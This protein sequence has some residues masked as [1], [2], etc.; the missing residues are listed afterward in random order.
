MKYSSPGSMTNKQQDKE[1]QS[2][3]IIILNL[4]LSIFFSEYWTKQK[5]SKEPGREDDIIL[6]QGNRITSRR[7][8]KQ[9][10]DL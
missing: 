3:S 6:C 9:Y 5:E 1:I 8:R 7:T 2:N 4:F 10:V